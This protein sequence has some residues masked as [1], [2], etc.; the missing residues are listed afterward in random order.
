MGTFRVSI[1]PTEAKASGVPRPTGAWDK[2]GSNTQPQHLLAASLP[3]ARM[4][5]RLENGCRVWIDQ[6]DKGIETDL[7]SRL[8]AVWG[9]VI[10]EEMDIHGRRFSAPS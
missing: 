2:V 5:G 8:L 4:V 9:P 3:Q 7:P 6:V 10:G 1:A